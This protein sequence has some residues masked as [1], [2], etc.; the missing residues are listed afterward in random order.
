MINLDEKWVAKQLAILEK[1]NHKREYE[2]KRIQE[3]IDVKDEEHDPFD[4]D[5][6]ASFTCS[7]LTRIITE[8]IGTQTEYIYTEKPPIRVIHDCTPEVK[9]AC[10]KVSIKCGISTAT[11]TVA[12]QA[13]C[14]E[15]YHHQ[16]YLTKEEAIERDL[17]L[18]ECSREQPSYQPKKKCRFDE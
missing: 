13:V 2:Y 8:D 18:I 17:S 10:V 7:G 5:I 14:E 9:N 4:I 6:D 15:F 3:Y 11:A 12:V 1:E 16:Y